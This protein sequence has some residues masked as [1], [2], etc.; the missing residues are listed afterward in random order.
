[1]SGPQKSMISEVTYRA[2]SKALKRGITFWYAAK[3]TAM[4]ELRNL[5]YSFIEESISSFTSWFLQ[6]Y[7]KSI[8]GR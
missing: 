1:M 2:G 8:A 7:I 4:R 6:S 5:G 3:K